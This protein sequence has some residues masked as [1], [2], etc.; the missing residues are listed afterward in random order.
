MILQLHMCS[1]KEAVS[2]MDPSDQAILSHW[3]SY[4]Q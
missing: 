3:A 1:G 4:R 2:L